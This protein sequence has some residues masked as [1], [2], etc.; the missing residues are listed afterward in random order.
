MIPSGRSGISQRIGELRW[1]KVHSCPSTFQRLRAKRLARVRWRTD[2][3]RRGVMLLAQAERRLGIADQL[4][5]VI[6]GG[7]DPSR[8]PPI[9]FP[10]FS[11]PAPSPSP[12]AAPRSW[13]GVT[14]TGSASFLGCPATPCLTGWST[15]P[16]TTFAAAGSL[17]RNP[18]CVRRHK[19]PGQV[20]EQ[21]RPR[22]RPDRATTKGL[23]IRFV[24]TSIKT[25]SAEHIYEALYCA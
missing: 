17:T 2:H 7:R 19:L 8:V 18:A 5:A 1:T 20:L 12:A 15:R 11:V 25:G 14:K 10:I 13:S 21:G 6:P 9:C 23:D 22:R 16:P 24:V 4:A 3:L